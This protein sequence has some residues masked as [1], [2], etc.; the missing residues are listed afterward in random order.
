MASVD[1]TH[2]N[3]Y[4]K[5]I[6]KEW[7]LVLISFMKSNRSQDQMASVDLIHNNLYT[8]GVKKEWVLVL[9]SFIKS[10]R[11]QDQMAFSYRSR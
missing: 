4:T 2:Y 7:V 10:N 11:S 9:I 3:L 6:K 5:A 1:F 8:K